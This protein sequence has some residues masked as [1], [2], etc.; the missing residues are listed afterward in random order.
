MNLSVICPGI[1]TQ[2]WSRLYE[3]INNDFTGTWEIIFV[4]PYELPEELKCCRNIKY[5]QDWGSPI[6]CQQMGLLKAEGDYITWAADDGYFLKGALNIAFSKLE[7]NALVMGKYYEGN[8][9]GDFPMQDNSY[10]ILSNHD[11]TKIKYVPKNYYM[12]NVGVVPRDILLKLGGWDCQFEVCPMAY[13]DL[14]IRLQRYGIKFIIQNEMMFTCSHLPGHEGDHG[15]I[16]DAQTQH[17]EQLFREI[18]SYSASTGR[19]EIKLNNWEK[20]PNRWLRRFGVLP[21]V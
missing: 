4:G 7:P 8:N 15:P 20:S 19:I 2:N 16:H 13:N 1:R 17:D 10:Y 14:A 5:I 21:K 18:Y 11:A 12:L 6:R 3:S 9:N